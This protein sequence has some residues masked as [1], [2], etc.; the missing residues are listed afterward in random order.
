MQGRLKGVEQG[1]LT[2]LHPLTSYISITTSLLLCRGIS[3]II[4]CKRR[5]N[6]IKSLKATELSQKKK[7]G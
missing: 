5:S 6:D 1:Q 4:Y 3:Y 7:S 2:D